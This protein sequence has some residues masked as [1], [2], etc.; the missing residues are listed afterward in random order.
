[1]N[2]ALPG[3]NEPFAKQLSDRRISFGKL[4]AVFHPELFK[5]P[6]SPFSSVS[7]EC[8]ESDS[9]SGRR[10]LSEIL[11]AADDPRVIDAE[12]YFSVSADL[13]PRPLEEV[14]LADCHRQLL[15]IKGL[16]QEKEAEDGS[17]EAFALKLVKEVI[18]LERR[19]GKI[20]PQKLTSAYNRQRAIAHAPLLTEKEVSEALDLLPAFQAS[21]IEHYLDEL[22]S[23]CTRAFYRTM[24]KE[25]KSYHAKGPLTEI[26]LTRYERFFNVRLRR[27]I[28]QFR[29]LLIHIVRAA[30]L[31]NM[32][33]VRQS[34]AL[35]EKLLDKL[36]SFG[37]FSLND[38]FS[39]NPIDEC[40]LIWQAE[41]AKIPTLFREGYEAGI[42][43]A[44]SSS[45]LLEPDLPKLSFDADSDFAPICLQLKDGSELVLTQTGLIVNE[46]LFPFSGIETLFYC[47]SPVRAT[48]ND[49]NTFI[50]CFGFRTFDH[51]E[52][53]FRFDEES[54]WSD[55]SSVFN[56]YAFPL[57]SEKNTEHLRVGGRFS[58]N[59]VRI[60]DNGIE[61]PQKGRFWGDLSF[62]FYPWKDVFIEFS[63][64]F[65][66][67]HAGSEKAY[68][69][70]WKEAYITN[71]YP[72]LK[73]QS[74]KTLDRLSE[75]IPIF[76]L[77]ARSVW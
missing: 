22:P 15:A 48:P 77:Q 34:Y 6:N 33:Q 17:V 30:R 45:S 56:D 1:M 64:N 3:L 62:V 29:S 7:Q 70:T 39:L 9:Y 71:L 46:E 20:S 49:P 21:F 40:Y 19:T 61:L 27:A 32:D 12:S 31:N 66:I 26:L 63:D 38:R 4:P 10:L 14:T 73:R 75:Q 25:R 47:N 50:H 76:E 42:V 23:N 74:I 69:D 2:S 5:K 57:I 13:D 51:Q 52:K 54:E 18:A 43:R 8:S 60:T 41:K 37:A 58:F 36:S 44:L 72:L 55:F 68:I 28:R 53:R 35:A 11:S 24:L 59:N 65:V 16:A 67:L